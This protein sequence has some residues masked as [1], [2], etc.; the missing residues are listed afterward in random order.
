VPTLKRNQV[1]DYVHEG[2]PEV[3]LD[4]SLLKFI[5]LNL[6]SNARKFSPEN[7]LIEIKTGHRNE[8]VILSVRDHG[9]GI[10]EQDQAHLMERFFRGANATNIQGTGLGLNIVAKY[11]EM[12]AGML[13]FNSELEK[14]TEFIITLNDKTG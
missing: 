12:M 5:L 9:I 3:F 4:K 10:S 14:G 7:S 11:V 6:V 8:Q 2:N 13:T 1:I